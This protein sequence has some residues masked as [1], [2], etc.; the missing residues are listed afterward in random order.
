MVV[1]SRFD[2]NDSPGAVGHSRS[3]GVRTQGKSKGKKTMIY[4][5]RKYDLKPRTLAQYDSILEKS[6]G[7]G[8]LNH[9]PLFGYWYSEFG[10]LNQALHIWPYRDLQERT[11][12]REQVSSLDSWPPPTSPLLAGQNTEIYVPAPFNDESVT[13]EQ[14]PYY[15]LRTYMYAAGDIPKVID[16]WSKAIDERRKH[17]SFI[18]AWYTE[19]GDLNR[20]AHIWAYTS[21]EERARVRAEMIERKIWP[22]PG[23]PVPLSQANTLYLPFSFSPLT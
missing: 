3:A 7:A 18:G 9:S 8:R 17:S 19:I 14:G 1:L 5:F 10:Q 11:E 4:E 2:D 20:W 12:V 13:G 15:E 16:A 23:G 22:A 21:L 6:L